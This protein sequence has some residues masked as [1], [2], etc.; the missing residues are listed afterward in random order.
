MVLAGSVAEHL[1]NQ[2]VMLMSEFYLVLQWNDIHLHEHTAFAHPSAHENLKSFFA[3]LGEQ[4]CA[5]FTL[6]L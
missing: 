3:W 2:V 1:P 4:G 5:S 6:R